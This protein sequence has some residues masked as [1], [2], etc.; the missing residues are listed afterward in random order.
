[1]RLRSRGFLSKRFFPLFLLLLLVLAFLMGEAF[2][3][4]YLRQS[5]NALHGQMARNRAPDGS[6]FSLK[7]IIMP[8]NN[9]RLIYELIP[10]RY[11]TYKA[12][13]YRSNSRGMR[14][15]ERPL[16]K[17]PGVWRIATLGDSTMFGSG[18][19]QD[20]S[21][22]ALLEEALNSIKDSRCYEVLNFAVPGYNTAIE[23]ET[24]EVRAAKFS[25]DLAL[26]QF[27]IND[28]ALPNFIQETPSLLA[29]DRSYLVSAVK[30]LLKGKSAKNALMRIAETQLKKTPLSRVKVGDEIIRFFEYRAEF[31]PEPYRYMVGWE[32][33]IRALK[34]LWS[35]T[36][37][38]ILHLSN[39]YPFTS[40]GFFQE[41]GLDP[42]TRCVQEAAAK[43]AGR[44]PLFVLDIRLVGED[45]SS[46][47]GINAVQDLSVDFPQDPHPSR[48]RHA[49]LARA[50]Y[51]SLIENG[52]LP[53][54]SVHYEEHE[55]VARFLWNKALEFW[56]K[57]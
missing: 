54:N 38:P 19:G 8:S 1:M 10:N 15:P 33:V 29:L 55:K 51:R 20:E 37:K 21:Y 23:V 48:E 47:L 9:P 39:P 52:L 2:L 34:H 22:P 16:E 24:F 32:G 17:A 12:K 41:D 35:V 26:I 43:P 11:G 14:S 45:F 31:T 56:S 27:D 50:I 42:Y 44:A 18:V 40:T 5:Q 4:I 53:E 57:R 25:P 13:P 49:L 30:S 46:E 36:D 7:D 28:L 6:N 3:R